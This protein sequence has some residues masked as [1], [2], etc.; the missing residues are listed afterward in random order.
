MLRYLLA[1]AVLASPAAAQ[2]SFFAEVQPEPQ[3][4][5]VLMAHGH[6][7]L[8]AQ[9]PT[10]EELDATVERWRA[11]TNPTSEVVVSNGPSATFIVTYTGFGAFPEA[12]AAFQAA[13]D[14]WATHIASAV[15]IRLTAEFTPL[16]TGV[17]GSAGPFLISDFTGAP[18]TNTWY[19]YAMADAIAGT[20]LVAG[21]ADLRSRFSSNFT[22][23]Y[24]GTDGNPPAGSYDF[25]SVVLHE[26]GH[27]LG[28]SGSARWDDGTTAGRCNGVTGN[29]CWGY[30]G[31]TFGGAPQIFDRFA[32]ARD[33]T[34]LLDVSLYPN[35][36]A[37]L[38][39][40]ITTSG[41]VFIRG[42]RIRD[43]YGLRALLYIP[44]A[45]QAGS[46]YSHWS[47]GA[48]PTGSINALMTPQ[49]A[50][51]ESF[52][53]P[54]PL[55]CAFFADMGWPMGPGCQ[56][57]VSDES[58]P[59]QASAALR[60][61]GANPFSDATRLQ[62]SLDAPEALEVALYDVTGRRVRLLFDGTAPAGT[63]SLDVRA[64]GLASGVY[65]VRAT[66]GTAVSTARVVVAR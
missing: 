26:L 59:S 16:G 62:L 39:A 23:W 19:P 2:S 20:D 14:I 3:T 24:F 25:R 30:N 43:T 8:D 47:E 63:L 45:W 64:S 6:G 65:S 52:D 57:I 17:L 18:Q 56:S 27:G 49:I 66:A 10:A 31:N 5:C 50:P 4:S 38:G 44:T 22:N 58:G 60:V 1:A 29:G 12:Q 21:A 36:S 51:G 40:L 54:G 46:S 42:P 28:F 11:Q 48:F 34:A 33:S 53:S 35:P 15:P 55:T 41:R 37:A 7:H 9:A 32:E 61:V 13:V